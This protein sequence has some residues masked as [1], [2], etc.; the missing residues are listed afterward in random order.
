MPIFVSKDLRNIVIFSLIAIVLALIIDYAF[1]AVDGLKDTMGALVWGFIRMYT[2]TAAALIVGGPSL[3][4][5]YLRINGRVAIVYLAAPFITFAALS[6]YLAILL[7]AG[8]FTTR[9]IMSLLSIPSIDFPAFIALTLFNAYIA[10]LTLNAIFALG[11]EIGWRGYLLDKFQSIGMGLVKSS[12]FVGA[13][14]GVWHASAIILL[15]HNYP[16]NRLAGAFLFVV[17]TISATLPH[18]FVRNVSSSVLPAASLHGSINAVWGLTILTTDLPRE[19]AGLGPIAYASWT[20]I[21]LAIYL[22]V[23]RGRVLGMRHRGPC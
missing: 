21:S 13:I 14:W 15:G 20:A 5:K 1:Y 23:I 22:M 10:S 9:Q 2:P 4:K 19:V 7:G 8:A 3:L 11:E 12:I 18:V 16:D 17:F 6:I